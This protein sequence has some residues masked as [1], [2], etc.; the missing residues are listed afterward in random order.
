[1]KRS[2]VES[3]GLS[4][5][6]FLKGAGVLGTVAAG[7]AVLGGCAPSQSEERGAQQGAKV[8]AVTQRLIDRGVAGAGLPDAAP[9]PPVEAP[10]SWDDEADVVVVGMGGGGLVA[11]GYLAQQGLKVVALEKEATVGGASRHA[12]S[13]VNVFGGTKSQNEIG[14]PGFFGGDANVAIAAAQGTSGFSI[15]EKFLRSL[16][17]N[18]AEGFDWIFDQEGMDFVCG[19]LLWHDADVVA[20]KQN[21]VLGMD[22]GI[23]ALEAAAIGYGADIRANTPVA[24]FVSD[25]ERVIGVK[26]HDAAGN[27]AYIKA[28]KGVILT[29]GG[30]GMN[31][32]LIKA[33]LP[34]AYEGA[35]LG[36]PM[37][38]HTG[39]IFR[40]GLG[41]GADFAGY[42]S[43][44]CWEGAID[45]TIA[46]GDGE[47][48][49]YFWH[50]E[51]QLFHNPWLV[52][53]K[54]GDRQPYYA[55]NQPAFAATGCPNSN[56]GDLATTAAWMSAPGH[57][58]YNI[59]DSKYPTEV[60]KKKVVNTEDPFNGDD[61]RIPITDPAVVRE[62]GG[63][64]TADW[65]A[66]VEEAVERGAVKKADTL[67]ELAEKLG[68][69]PE[70]VV[71]AT[72]RYNALCEKGFDDEL[73]IPYD[74]SWLS[75]IDTPPYYAAIVGGQIG[76][77]LCGL[78]VNDKF[79]VCSEEAEAIPGLYAGFSTLGGMDGE[80]NYGCFW[81]GGTFFGGIGSTLV[82][83]YIAAKMLLENE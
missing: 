77:T 46:G 42:D 1:M 71:G 44:C 14:F 40:M 78:R 10:A 9:I 15:N 81:N 34:S 6:S 13:V 51:R 25:G 69:K 23:D 52:I 29:A 30:F 43:W 37:P 28:N 38:S 26:V 36:G 22:K 49:H 57:H 54:F 72:E 39:E 50:G 4:R 56:M 48:W 74:P 27:D 55:Y 70:V 62:N 2:N 17:A 47:F 20:K 35:V 82:T 65:L 61:C 83:G 11:A 31:K 68:L 3:K 63:L 19:G 18:Q 79:Q 21:H 66:E 5:R 7:G 73:A 24:A 33:Y 8:D 32:D 76:K 59:C 64:V 53:D 16:L 80:G 75:P 41:V 45:E 12:C 67:E 58:V 60:F